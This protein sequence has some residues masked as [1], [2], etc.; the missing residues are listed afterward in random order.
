M[1]IFLLDII[2]EQTNILEMYIKNYFVLIY[3]IKVKHVLT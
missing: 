3:Q 2:K 1:L